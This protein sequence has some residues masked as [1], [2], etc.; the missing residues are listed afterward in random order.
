LGDEQ[1]NIVPDLE[2]E[3]KPALMGIWNCVRMVFVGISWTMRVVREVEPPPLGTT[4]SGVGGLEAVG[5]LR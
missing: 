4:F 3:M 5:P 2:T 1:N